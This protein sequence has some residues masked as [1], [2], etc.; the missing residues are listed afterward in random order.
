MEPRE[1]GGRGDDLAPFPGV[2]GVGGRQDADSDVGKGG[3]GGRPY[4]LV[5]GGDSHDG[6]RSVNRRGSESKVEPLYPHKKK[7]VHGPSLTHY[8]TVTPSRIHPNHPVCI[9]LLFL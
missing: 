3:V 7:R 8:S 6:T 5:S 9:T 2:L 1:E 4:V